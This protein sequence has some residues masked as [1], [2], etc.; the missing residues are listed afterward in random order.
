VGSDRSSRAVSAYSSRYGSKFSNRSGGC[1]TRVA[2][3]GAGFEG[4]AQNGLE[5]NFV[6]IG[7]NYV[8]KNLLA[9]TM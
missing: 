8:T 5:T 1:N 4:A 2:R 9:Q 6:I 7:A 3:C